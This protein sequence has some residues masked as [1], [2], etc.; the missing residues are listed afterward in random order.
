MVHIFQDEYYHGNVEKTKKN[1][2]KPSA[3]LRLLKCIYIWKNICFSN[4][5]MT[6][7]TISFQ[8]MGKNI[9]GL[10]GTKID[11][12]IKI[13]H[14]MENLFAPPVL[15]STY[16]QQSAPLYWYYSL[17]LTQTIPFILYYMQAHQKACR[18]SRQ[19][20]KDNKSTCPAPSSLNTEVK[21]MKPL[22]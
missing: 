9:S 11:K 12:T 13:S 7:K 1:Q 6:D 18:R 15:L 17:F 21:D 14:C 2:K 20:L 5:R 3:S 19:M 16:C 22:S 10:C 8:H 4:S